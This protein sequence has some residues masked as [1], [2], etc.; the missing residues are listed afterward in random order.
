MV[1]LFKTAL[2]YGFDLPLIGLVAIAS[3]LSVLLNGIVANL[4]STQFRCLIAAN[5]DKR[6][7]EIK[8]EYEQIASDLD[9]Q[10]AATIGKVERVL[11]I[12]AVALGQYALISG[13]LV[14]KAF[15][16]WL[17]PREQE[18]KA[19]NYYHLY[20]YGNL[21]SLLLGVGLGMLALGLSKAAWHLI[22]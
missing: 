22:G 15:S 12:I 2:A 8:Q 14:L 21:L 9:M 19:M 4:H 16:A 6:I 20:L 7:G 3:L 11:Y 5:L 10:F 1:A 17:R 13:W 18:P